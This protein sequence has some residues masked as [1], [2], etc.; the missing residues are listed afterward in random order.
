[1]NSRLSSID[2]LR[3][4]AMTMV[5]AVHCG[6][7]PF[8][9]MGVWLFYVI[10]G[11]VI[12]RNFIA[13]RETGIPK[14]PHYASFVTRRFFRIVPPY[15]AYIAICAV[16]I[17]AFGAPWQFRDLP[18]LVTFTHNWWMLVHQSYVQTAWFGF[19]HLW[20][21]STEE[22]FY[23]VFPL[24]FFAVP[25]RR[26]P[27]VVGVLIKAGPLIRWALAHAL[28][29]MGVFGSQAVSFSIYFSSI[30][31]FDAFL[32]GSLLA[33]YETDIRNKT[34]IARGLAILSL[35]AVALYCSIYVLINDIVL[36][37]TGFALFDGLFNAW[38]FGQG[39]EYVVYSVIDLCAAAL[40]AL[41]IRGPRLL[42]FPEPITWIGLNSY[43][44]YLYHGLALMLFSR[45]VLHIDPWSFVEP[46]APSVLVRLAAFSVTLFAT[47]A[48]AFASYTFLERRSLAIGHR[49]STIIGR[50]SGELVHVQAA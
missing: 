27:V 10:S 1:V 7:F 12:T 11:F 43:S 35:Y 3:A 5:I 44:G 45:L 2:G 26:F 37:A 28:A 22:Q 18:Y 23:L 14:L 38:A 13:E 40:V 46:D 24:L 30:G 6:S 34:E 29:A 50:K 20:T 15:F 41:A 39:R 25:A 4:I 48:A 21:I 36:G 17:A 31:Q 49:L 19:L 8:G 42:R 47:M 9:W 33:H 32:I 16:L